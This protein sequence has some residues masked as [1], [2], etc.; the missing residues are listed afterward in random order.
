MSAR[1]Y[2]SCQEVFII[3]NMTS[4]PSYTWFLKYTLPVAAFLLI[5]FSIQASSV[6]H[7]PKYVVSILIGI[8]SSI[9]L[10]WMTYQD[11]VV[12]VR[13]GSQKISIIY[14]GREESIAWSEIKYIDQ[15]LFL[16][17][18][19]YKLKL[20]NRLGYF[21]FATQPHYVNFG[22]GTRDLSEMGALIRKRKKEWG[23]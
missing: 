8:S 16:D 15:L 4:S 17:I 9:I 14:Q 12:K 11:R 6:E 21:L 2:T 10:F 3:D 13:L 19:V 7:N 20:K 18:P 23:I 22:F 1:K 5:T